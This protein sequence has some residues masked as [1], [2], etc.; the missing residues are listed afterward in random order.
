MDNKKEKDS[1]PIKDSIFRA[2]LTSV[3]YAGPVIDHLIYDTANAMITQNMQEC[4]DALTKKI[5]RFEE[6]AIN[7]EWFNSKEAISLFKVLFQKVAHEP[8]NEKIKILGEATAVL[9]L[10]VNSND[11]KKIQHLEYI[12]NL[13][14]SQVEL[15][16]IIASLPIKGMKVK[17]RLGS[18]E[19]LQGIWP[20]EI[21]SKITSEK[22]NLLE[23][24][25]EDLDI[26]ECHNI[27]RRTQTAYINHEIE[28]YFTL[29]NL[30][31]MLL[32]YIK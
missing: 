11:N 30:G 17:N 29:T 20:N 23:S 19:Y 5:K 7:K 28:D 14:V 21:K 10:K 1:L 4:L 25:E 13:T 32:K 2:F 31:Q 16:K 18:S 8:D 24:Y 3:P 9:A 27:I 22:S 26:L 6:E 15:L 12:G